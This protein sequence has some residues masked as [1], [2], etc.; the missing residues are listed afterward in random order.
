M[1]F[2]TFSVRD[3]KKML[4]RN[5]GYRGLAANASTA[6]SAYSENWNYSITDEEQ[7]IED[8]ANVQVSELDVERMF[9]P[10]EVPTNSTIVKR[11]MTVDMAT[12][13]FDNL[14]M[15]YWELWEHFGF[16]CRDIKYSVTNTNREA[17]IMIKD[18]QYAH[19][20]RNEDM[21]IDVQGFGFLRDCFPKCIQFS[22]ATQATKRSKAQ[23]KTLK[24]ESAHLAMELIHAGLIH[25]EP[26]LSNMHYMHKNMKR[27]GGTTI[28][29]QMKFE[30]VIFQFS[31]TPNGRI[32]V[33]DK[34]KQH[35]LLKGMSPDLFD[36]IIMLCGG[37]FH[38]CYNLL[39]DD[40][41]VMRKRMQADDMFALLNVNGDGGTNVDTRLERKKIRNVSNILDVL[42]RI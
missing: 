24:D 12:T 20:L 38:T 19:A 22:G 3:N 2:Y 30:S 9:R 23:Y 14:V 40:A 29:R 31:R 18:F 16:V 15:K 35:S 33:L 41:G 37:A 17:V 27:T 10:M 36:N 34:E 32:V 39:R 25:Y 21:I 11:F 4:S 42:S 8:L 6:A 26:R 7:D 5:K 28:I 1:V 13:G